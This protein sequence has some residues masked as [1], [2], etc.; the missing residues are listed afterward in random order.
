MALTVISGRNF[1]PIEASQHSKY[2]VK[3]EMAASWATTLDSTVNFLTK[4][5]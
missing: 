5:K 1:L 4:S 2:A 3:R